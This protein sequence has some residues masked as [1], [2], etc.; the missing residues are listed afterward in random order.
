MRTD[1]VAPCFLK[2]TLPAYLWEKDI[3]SA[4]IPPVL[5]A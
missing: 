4:F 5:A 2:E 1:E 3:L